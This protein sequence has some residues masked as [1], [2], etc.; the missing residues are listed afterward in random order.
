[1]NNNELKEKMKKIL[2]HGVDIETETMKPRLL[3]DKIINEL[4]TLFTEMVEGELQK[5]SDWLA[6]KEFA[7]DSKETV[8]TETINKWRFVL[9]NYLSQERAKN[10]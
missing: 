6:M 8:P 4:T 2:W 9:N 7:T 1:M 5:Y 3:E 10:D